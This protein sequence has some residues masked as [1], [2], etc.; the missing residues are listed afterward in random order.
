MWIV[1]PN[2][3]VGDRSWSAL[4]SNQT[5]RGTLYALLWWLFAEE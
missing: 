1:N 5:R 3:R 2:W 4:V